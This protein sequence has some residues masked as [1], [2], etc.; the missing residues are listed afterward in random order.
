M[1]VH[2]DTARRKRAGEEADS[3]SQEEFQGRGLERLAETGGL[4]NVDPD[5][6]LV[7]GTGVARAL[8]AVINRLDP[9][10][11]VF[12][13]TLLTKVV[14]NVHGDSSGVRRA[15]WLWPSRPNF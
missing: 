5:A 10:A 14:L 13:D 6:G 7:L 2:C 12:S 8:A 9:D 3:G 4:P 15:A 11:V 1:I